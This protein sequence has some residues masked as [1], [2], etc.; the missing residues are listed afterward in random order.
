MSRALKHDI[1]G[2][3]FRV[4]LAEVAER[5]F[6]EIF[7]A[8][9]AKPLPLVLEIGFGRGEF[10]LHLA[11]EQ[12]ETAFVGIE[13]SSKRVLKLARRLARS[14]LRNVR[15]VEARAEELVAEGLPDASV[16]CCWVNFPDPW[17]KKRHFK[18]RLIQP[19]MVAALRAR[20]EPGGLL[21]LATDHSGY[22]EWID[23]VL[24]AAP[25]LENRYAPDPFRPEAP[26]RMPTAYELEWRALGRSLHFFEYARTP[27]A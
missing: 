6:P 20:L 7:G 15:L 18:R 14:T 9:V 10:L 8:D 23:E 21:R 17:P 1:P 27:D 3:D 13:Y 24:R 4:G 16:S 22:A 26:G 19:E 5:G 25:G 11:A 2:I 12:P